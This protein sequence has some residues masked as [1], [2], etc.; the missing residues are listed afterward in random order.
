MNL[1]DLGADV[2]KVERPGS[3]DDT[4]SWGPPWTQNGSSTYYLGLNRG[5][6]IVALDLKNPHDHQLARRLAIRADVLIENF[7]A[8]VMDDFNLG[9]DALRQENPGLVYCSISGFASSGSAASLPGYDLLI[10]AMSGLMSVTGQ[11]DDVPTKVGSAITDMAAGLYATIGV[12]AA[13]QERTNTGL[14][15]KVEVSLFDAALNALLNQGSA[16]VNAEVVPTAQGN[17]HPSIAPYESFPSAD[18]DFILAAANDRLWLRTCKAIER[19]DLAADPRFYTNTDR[20]NHV[21]ALVEELRGTFRTRPA[22][23]WIRVLR[24]AGV[25]AGPINQI[26]E[27][28][29]WA[30]D[31]GL[32]P[33][34]GFDSSDVRTVRSPIRL[35]GSPVGATIPPPALDEHGPDIRAW[36][37]QD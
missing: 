33:T 22:E 23:H 2:V 6:R 32:D 5:K 9:Y 17:R 12:L 20:R 4:R 30:V 25:P 26:D 14:G 16:Y 34:V 13:I 27:A 10:Q 36:L 19:P 31:Q 15:Q 21:D 7:R 24:D 37:E 35:S 8:R 11:P 3:G 18:R 1:A 28:F 29:A